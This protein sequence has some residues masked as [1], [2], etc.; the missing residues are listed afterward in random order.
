MH[1]VDRLHPREADWAMGTG[2]NFKAFSTSW[3]CCYSCSSSDDKRQEEQGQEQEQEQ[4]QDLPVSPSNE[5]LFRKV[6]KT[7]TFPEIGI[8]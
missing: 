7:T 1:A 2:G 5:I 8:S 4:E 3:V 6:W